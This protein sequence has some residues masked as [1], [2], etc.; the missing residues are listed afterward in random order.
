[1]ILGSNFRVLEPDTQTELIGESDNLESGL[2]GFTVYHV[3]FARIGTDRV[4][5]RIVS[6]QNSSQ[7]IH[8]SS[9]AHFPDVHG[10]PN[11]PVNCQ[12]VIPSFILTRHLSGS[13]APVHQFWYQS[14]HSVSR[15]SFSHP[16][17][18]CKPF[19]AERYHSLLLIL[20]SFV[21]MNAR[22]D[23]SSK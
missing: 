17:M 12:S 10:P 3:N 20:H 23:F 18:W 19:S 14:K 21:E 22:L 4:R 1:M 5:G 11:P 9:P 15:A 13:A 7:R 2:T 8:R 16:S 6:V